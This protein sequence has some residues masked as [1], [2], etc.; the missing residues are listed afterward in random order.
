MDWLKDFLRPEL[1]W[2]VVGLVL[3]VAEFIVPGL[4][5]A[6]FAVGA[7]IVAVVCL[8]TPLSLNAQLG[9]FIVSSVVLLV[10]VRRWVKGLFGGFA[11]D[12]QNANID[13]DEYIGQRAIVT[14]EI[15]PKLAGRVEFHGTHWTAQAD[16]EIAVGAV[17]EIMQKSSATL[18]VKRI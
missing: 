14:S 6:F 10:G 5:I 18:K 2:F 3:L 17:V 1:I 13:L 15:T 8:I 9:V 12:K 7:W 4:I 16:E 11:T